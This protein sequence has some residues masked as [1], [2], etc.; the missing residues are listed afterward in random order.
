MNGGTLYGVATPIG[1]LED[2]TLRALKV[3][4]ECDMILCEDTRRTRKL[5]S[6]YGIKKPTVSYFEGNEEK[7]VPEVMEVLRSGKKVALVSDAG[8]PL[9][10]D[11]G[12][13]LV[14]KCRESGI[15]VIP[16]PGASAVISAISVSG[17]ETDKFVFMGFPPRRKGKR[18]KVIESLGG[19]DGSVVFYVSP[20]KVKEFLG[21]I[22][23][24][25]GDRYVCVCREMTKAHEEYIFGRVSEVRDK[26]KEKGEM[27]VVVGKT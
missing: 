9:I 21:E 20:Y 5:L 26:V 10:S 19:F 15:S 24:I 7:R 2:I 12:Y 18:K 3:L 27:V 23:S 14:R 6:H 22:E 25:L 13:R 1:N 16:V 4:K 8:T 11:P 17:L